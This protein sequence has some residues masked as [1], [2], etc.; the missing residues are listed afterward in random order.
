MVACPARAQ[1]APPSPLVQGDVLELA[2]RALRR[3]VRR[4]PRGEPDDAAGA[5][6]MP[7]EPQRAQRGSK[8]EEQQGVLERRL[9]ITATPYACPTAAAASPAS[10][11]QMTTK[12]PS[13]CPTSLTTHMS[14]HPS[15]CI[16]HPQTDPARSR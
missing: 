3:A 13:P 12:L 5:R 2:D 15:P 10:M 6:R 16:T 4:G 9:T 8:R 14:T 1:P 11:C 7:H